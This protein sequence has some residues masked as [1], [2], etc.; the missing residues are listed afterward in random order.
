MS[1]LVT[2]NLHAAHRKRSLVKILTHR[3][4]MQIISDV[5]EYAKVNTSS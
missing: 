2:N 1:M 3:I 5:T 4:I